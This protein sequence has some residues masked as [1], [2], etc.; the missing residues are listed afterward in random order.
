MAVAWQHVHEPPP[1]L[2]AL[3]PDMWPETA[4][5]VRR[6]MAK[7]PDARFQTAAEM[8]AALQAI[9]ARL[10]ADITTFR[11]PTAAAE[12]AM[13]PPLVAPPQVSVR[14]WSQVRRADGAPTGEMARV[15][16]PPDDTSAPDPAPTQTLVPY[17]RAGR[18]RPPGARNH[19]A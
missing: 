1:D 3:R 13:T 12:P 15:A 18:R 14:G 2:L 7:E 8:R 6:A 4:A 17:R 10:L 19:P 5:L 9:R 11:P 16:P